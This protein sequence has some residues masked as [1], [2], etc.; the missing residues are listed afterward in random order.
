MGFGTC[1]FA[2]QYVIAA[3]FALWATTHYALFVIKLSMQIAKI[4]GISTDP[5]RARIP[6]IGRS[7][8][9]CENGILGE[10]RKLV[11]DRDAK[12]CEDFR[13]LLA[14]AGCEILRLLPRSRNPNAYAERFGGSIKAECLNRVIFFGE[15][16]LRRAIREYVPHFRR[17]RNHQ[18]LD[19]RVP[20]QSENDSSHSLGGLR[21]ISRLGGTLSYHERIA[22]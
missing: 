16:R 11:I 20:H 21:R 15:A 1:F 8:I 17:E 9:D 3:A 2:L 7:L 12:Y 4:A 14:R 18:G 6:H 5:Y 22:A 13:V 19:E 10:E